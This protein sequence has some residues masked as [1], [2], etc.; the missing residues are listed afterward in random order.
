MEA[1]GAEAPRSSAFG[2]SRFER[3][4]CEDRGA[5]CTE[6]GWVW[7]EVP[8]P[9]TGKVWGEGQKIFRFLSSK[10]RVLVHSGTDKTY[11]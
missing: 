2:A 8:L 5:E 3:H 7:D 4:R 9:P 10:R 11:F 6:G 1:P